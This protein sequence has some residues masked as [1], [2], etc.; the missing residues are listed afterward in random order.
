MRRIF[1]R[2]AR[3]RL[4]RGGTPGMENPVPSGSGVGHAIAKALKALV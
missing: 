2:C 3:I 4:G 1:T